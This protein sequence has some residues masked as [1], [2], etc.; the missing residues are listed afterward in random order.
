MEKQNITEKEK[1]VQVFTPQFIT[2]GS[3]RQKI[4]IWGILIVFIILTLGIVLLCIQP[5][6]EPQTIVDINLQEMINISELSTVSS[7]YKGIADVRN[8][9]NKDNTDYY[10]SYTANV[11]A[12]IQLEEI[13]ISINESQ[14][15]VN[16]TLPPVTITNISIDPNSLEFLFINEKANTAETVKNALDA[17]E[18]DIARECDPQR[19]TSIYRLA[20]E[21]AKKAVQA[22]VEPIISQLKDPYTLVIE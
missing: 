8:A 5:E 10:V 13:S 9:A 18:N 16:I 15:T 17:C 12:G 3:L 20:A 22:L 14:R 2:H 7:Y 19:A 21:N 4:T 1:N 6:P 11:L